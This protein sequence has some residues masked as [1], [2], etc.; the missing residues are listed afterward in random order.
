[1]C[2]GTVPLLAWGRR[3]VAGSRWCL[4]QG[5]HCL[6]PSAGT[7]LLACLCGTCRQGALLWAK[8]MQ[9]LFAAAKEC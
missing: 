5:L 9:I 3:I 7:P 4:T 8:S 2:H 1:M 6:A